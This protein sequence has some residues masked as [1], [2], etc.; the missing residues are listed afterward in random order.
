MKARVLYLTIL[1][2][3]KI[4]L[5]LKVETDQLVLPECLSVKICGFTPSDT[6]RDGAD[7]ESPFPLFTLLVPHLRTLAQEKR[8]ENCLRFGTGVPNLCL[9]PL[10]SRNIIFCPSLTMAARA[11]KSKPSVCTILILSTLTH[12]EFDCVALQA[13]YIGYKTTKSMRAL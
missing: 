1:K 5:P 13:M 3:K 10:L 6:N 12:T 11:K 2:R 7:A 4:S 9:Y 8:S